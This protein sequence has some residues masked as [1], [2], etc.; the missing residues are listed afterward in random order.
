MLFG[1]KLYGTLT[2]EDGRSV[3][4][5]IEATRALACHTAV[6]NIPLQTYI[7]HFIR[8]TLVGVLSKRL[9]ESGM[10]ASFDLS[11]TGN[12]GISKNEGT[13]VWNFVSDSKWFADHRNRA[14]RRQCWTLGVVR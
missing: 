13:S 3:R 6:D 5:T 1:K 2:V 10:E 9:N 12:S 4:R 7:L 11:Y 8:A 14:C